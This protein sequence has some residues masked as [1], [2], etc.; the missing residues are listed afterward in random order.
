[1]DL[2]AF[3]ATITAVIMLVLFGRVD[4]AVL[5][6]AAGFI[7]GIFRVFRSR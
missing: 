7:V 2:V 5:A 1:M 4:V 6:G 3:L